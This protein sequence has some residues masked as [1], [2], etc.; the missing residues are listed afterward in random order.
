[1][2]QATRAAK[3]PLGMFLPTEQRNPRS[4]ALHELSPEEILELIN[5]EDKIA[6]AEARRV[7]P[8]TAELVR[9][10][11]DCISQGGSVHY[12]GAGTSGR[13][14]TQDAAELYPT[15]HTPPEVV[16]AHMAGGIDALLISVE[17]AEDDVAA[18]ARDASGLGLKDLAIGLAASGRTPYVGG[19]LEKARSNGAKTAIISCVPEPTLSQYA[20]VVIA[21]DTGPEVLTGSTRLKAGT[22]QKVLL[23]GFSTAVMVGLGR[24]YSNLMV[25]M[26]ATNEKLHSRSIRILMEGSGLSQDKAVDLLEQCSGDLK[27]ALVCGI[28]NTTPDSARPHLRAAGDVVHRALESINTTK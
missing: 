23:S 13:I 15:F 16:Q 6:I 25:S 19:A 3:H 18:G 26:V 20:D 2:A 17:N 10:A 28:S 24:T 11:I 7:I 14:A 1:M 22:F 27:L 4:T 5:D 8:L 9:I 12:F 21:G